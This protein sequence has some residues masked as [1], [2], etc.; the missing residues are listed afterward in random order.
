MWIRL[1]FKSKSDNYTELFAIDV[2]GRWR[3]RNVWYPGRSVWYVLKGTNIVQGN[4]AMLNM[5]E[6]AEVIVAEHPKGHFT[7]KGT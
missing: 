7:L 4:E 1:P 2:T 6:S 3:E 5:Q